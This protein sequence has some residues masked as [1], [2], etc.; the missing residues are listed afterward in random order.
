MLKCPKCKRVT[1]RGDSTG[2]FFTY[3]AFGKDIKGYQTVTEINVCMGCNG[4]K[5]EK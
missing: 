1:K 2:K 3:K 4:S 5:M